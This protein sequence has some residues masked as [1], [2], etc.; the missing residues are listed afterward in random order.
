MN[1][2]IFGGSAFIGTQL[3]KMIKA[4]YLKLLDNI[5]KLD[6]IMQGE[7][8]AVPSVVEKIESMNYYIRLDMRKS[9]DFE[10]TKNEDI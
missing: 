10:L 6:I 8:E 3:I 4:E 9:I 2:L 5:Y 7:A 1:H